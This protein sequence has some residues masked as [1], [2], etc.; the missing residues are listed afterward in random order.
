[1]SKL[2]V[3]SVL[4]VLILRI[5]IG[6]DMEFVIELKVDRQEVGRK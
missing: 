4:A 1:V 3:L 6:D 2:E 5:N